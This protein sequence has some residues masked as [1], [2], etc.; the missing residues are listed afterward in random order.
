MYI[1]IGSASQAMP[2]IGAV[3]TSP[4]SGS[5]QVLA[6]PQGTWS[7]AHV[8]SSGGSADVYR[9]VTSNSNPDLLSNHATKSKSRGAVLEPMGSSDNISSTAS[10]PTRRCACAVQ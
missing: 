3:L 9:V 5:T 7:V 8:D 6:S 10:E 1:E 4:H 2:N